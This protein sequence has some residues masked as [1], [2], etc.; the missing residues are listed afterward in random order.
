MRGEPPRRHKQKEQPEETKQLHLNRGGAR[1]RENSR[2]ANRERTAARRRMIKST[3]KKTA[4]K[5]G[6]GR[7]R[8]KTEH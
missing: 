4:A 2:K 8:M 6:E 5:T 7:K 3:K 1:E